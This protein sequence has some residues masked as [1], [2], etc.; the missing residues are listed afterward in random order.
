M[1]KIARLIFSGKTKIRLVFAACRVIKHTNEENPAEEAYMLSASFLI[2]IGFILLMSGAEYTVRGAVAIANKMRI[3]TIIV[4][5]TVVAFGTSAPEFVVSI[6]AALEGAAGISIGN[7]VGSN[8]ANILLILGVASLIYPIK[9]RR[10]IFLRDYKFLLVVSAV[11]VAF[12]LTGS[13]VRWQG[14]L[15]LLMLCGFVYYNYRNSKQSD[16]GSEA[17]SPI[18]H[19]KWHVVIEVTLLGLVGII[20]GAELLVQGAVDIA[21]ILGISEETIGLT[22]IAVGTSLPELATTIMAAI[23]RQNG[24][25]LGNVLGSNVWNIVFI[26]GFTSTI[27]EVKVPA[28]FIYYDLWVMLLATVLLFPV[29]MTRARI[30][31]GEGAVFL[32]MYVFYLA[33]QVLIT[34]GIWDFG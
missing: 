20:Y 27:V 29:M 17:L 13:F 33:S 19:K 18:A 10:R 1:V 21:R 22:V 32:I 6:R 24:V 2:I 14:I 11:F 15:M 28:Q 23:R 30:S 16:V 5:L 34:R 12:A 8:I 31:R 3:P 25:A 9:C 26:M 4:G 7:V